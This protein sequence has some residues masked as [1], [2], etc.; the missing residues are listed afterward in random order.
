LKMPSKIILKKS[1]VSARVPVA[2]DLEF[3]ELALNYADSKLYFKKADGTTVG[4]FSIP[5]EGVTSVAGLTGEVTT[6]NLSN[7][8]G[9]NNKQ[10]TL[11]SGQ[12]IKTINGETLL[13]STNLV[14]SASPAGQNNQLQYNNQNAF[15]GSANLTFDGTTLIAVKDAKINQLTIG[16]GSGDS[17]TNTAI[18]NFALNANQTPN[19]LSFGPGN[20]WNAG[21]NVPTDNFFNYNNVPTSFGSGATFQTY[22][23]V[24]VLIGYGTVYNV[25]LNTAG[26]GPSSNAATILNISKEY[27]GGANDITVVVTGWSSIENTAIGKS[28]MSRNTTGLKNSSLGFETFSYN[29]S[30]SRNVA[31]GHQAMNLSTT[32]N[33]SVAVGH[34]ALFNGSTNGDCVS[35]GYQAAYS[36]AASSSS[37]V[38][39]GSSAMRNHIDGTS[40][41]AVGSSA[42]FN[43][44]TASNSV[45]IGAAAGYNKSGNNNVAIGS[46]AFSGY[47]Q[48]ATCNDNIAI[49]FLSML[50]CTSGGNNVAIGSFSAYDNSSGTLNTS[51]GGAT[52]QRNTTGYSNTAVGFGS[53]NSITTGSENCLFG[54][55]SGATITTGSDNL[56]LGGSNY[57]AFEITT[58]NNRISVGSTSSSNAYIKVAWTVVSDARDK[59]DFAPV[60]H[61]LDFVSKLQTTAYRY[62][63]TRTDKEGHGPVRYGFKAQEVLALEGDTPVIV[64][65]EDLNKLR[66][67]DQAMIAVLVNAIQE[68]NSKFDN[69]ISTHP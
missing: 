23:T 55:G 69:Y 50:N 59:T 2:A 9:L 30:G 4:S 33:N 22:P 53:G 13:G 47:Q 6:S 31:V 5:I 18:G 8:L 54:R 46:N 35:I 49:G 37:N 7:Q 1:S 66:F 38:A 36:A 24:N 62:K 3:G 20:N 57:P 56:V 41:I 68:L 34:Q 25:S 44:A 26:V 60:P 15:A 10:N 27:I 29:T 64:D 16:R 51:I 58:Q 63:M 45:C 40:N 28:S 42:M 17:D 11:V 32:G 14:V 67:N 48:G 43:S 61:G 39:I 65:A 21:N 52:L 19:I 12:N